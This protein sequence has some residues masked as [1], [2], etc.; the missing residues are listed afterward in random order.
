MLDKK[1]YFLIEKVFS[2]FN[3]EQLLLFGAT[4]NKNIDVLFTFC[5]KKLVFYYV[6]K[7]NQFL[8][9]SNIKQGYIFSPSFLKVFYTEIILKNKY[10]FCQNKE[11]KYLNGSVIFVASKKTCEKVYMI[12]KKSLIKVGRLH[13]DM[14]IILRLLTMQMLMSKKINVLVCTDIGNRGLDYPFIDLVINYNFPKTT[15]AY[16]HR[17]G[18]VCRFNKKGHCIN[19][20]SDVEIDKFHFL[21][22]KTGFKI[23]KINFLND[24]HLL[25]IL[26]KPK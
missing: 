24:I 13:G 20:I 26:S 17:A 25:K 7:K 8:E 11:N 15:N 3:I 16:I 2:T 18:R 21:E 22:Q 4:I 1:I 9:F 10:K 6:D 14:D 5:Y 12:L 23:K 19:L